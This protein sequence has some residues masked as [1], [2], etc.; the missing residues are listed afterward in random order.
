MNQA[1]EGY[2]AIIGNYYVGK[3]IGRGTFGKVKMGLHT[4]TMENVAI[5]ILDKDKIVDESDKI[6]VA[7]EIQILRK[8]RHPNIIQL[9]EII[10]SQTQLFLITEYAPNNE[11]FDFIVKRNRLNERQSARFLLQILSAVEYL[12]QNNIVHRDLKPENLL[13]DCNN[14]IKVVDFGLSNMYED[15]QTLKTACGSPCYAAPEMVSGKRYEGLK[16]D[17]WSCGIILYAMLCGYL[18]FEDSNTTDLYKKIINDPVKLPKFL[19]DRSKSILNGI[20][21]KNPEKRLTIEAI[22][23]HDF[24]ILNSNQPILKGIIFGKDDILVDPL[25]LQIIK[26]QYG[27]D[28]EQARVMIQNNKHN[29]ITATYYLLLNSHIRNG[30]VS[31]AD[32]SR[33]PPK[34]TLSLN[35]ENN[36]KET[37][38]SSSKKI[39]EQNTILMENKDKNGLQQDKQSVNINYS[40]RVSAMNKQAP[41][42]SSTPIKKGVD[43]KPPLQN[44]E[45][46]VALQQRINKEKQKDSTPES[47]GKN[48]SYLNSPLI[49]SPEQNSKNA[50]ARILKEDKQPFVVV[51]SPL[52]NKQISYDESES[53]NKSPNISPNTNKSKYQDLQSSQK[54]KQSGEINFIKGY[55]LTESTVRK[56]NFFQEEEQINNISATK[57]KQNIQNIDVENQINNQ[58]AYTSTFGSGFKLSEKGSPIR[59]VKLNNIQQQQFQQSLQKGDTNIQ[60]CIIDKNEENIKLDKQKSQES[61]NLLSEK[62]LSKNNEKSDDEQLA[63]KSP[64]KE[65][66]MQIEGENKIRNQNVVATETKSASLD[67]KQINK[68]NN[69][70]Q[71]KVNGV[72]NLYNIQISKLHYNKAGQKARNG[73]ESTSEISANK[74]DNQVTLQNNSDIYQRTDA[75]INVQNY[76][77][78]SASRRGNSSKEESVTTQLQLQIIQQSENPQQINQI[79]NTNQSKIIVKIHQK[80]KS[81]TGFSRKL[82][83]INGIN[84]KENVNNESEEISNMKSPQL[85]SSVA[86][87]SAHSQVN[88]QIK[89]TNEKIANL[90]RSA[91]QKGGI[92]AFQKDVS[93]QSQYKQYLPVFFNN[94]QYSSSLNAP[95]TSNSIINNTINS[96]N[97]NN[98]TI[99]TEKQ[100]QNQSSNNYYSKQTLKTP[101]ITE[102]TYH[103][104]NSIRQKLKIISQ[105]NSTQGTS[106]QA[107]KVRIRK[108]ATPEL[109]NINSSINNNSNQSNIQ[110]TLFVNGSHN[111]VSQQQKRSNSNNNITNNQNSATGNSSNL[112]TSPEKKFKTKQISRSSRRFVSA[113]RENNQMIQQSLVDDP[114]KNKFFRQGS[115][116]IQKNIQNYLNIIEKNSASNMNNIHNTDKQNINVVIKKPEN[117]D[118][119]GQSFQS[120]MKKQDQTNNQTPS[121]NKEVK[122]PKIRVISE[123]PMCKKDQHSN[124]S[125]YYLGLKQQMIQKEPLICN[126]SINNDSN[127]NHHLTN[128][129]GINSTIDDIVQQKSNQKLTSWPHS[130]NYYLNAPVTHSNNKSYL[131]NISNSSRISSQLNEQQLQSLQPPTMENSRSEHLKFKAVTNSL[132]SNSYSLVNVQKYKV[133]KSKINSGL[134]NISNSIMSVNNAIS[135]HTKDKI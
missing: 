9:Y 121:I 12:H 19:T 2:F 50:D 100:Q 108:S 35:Q 42:K 63:E 31:I 81:E 67:K 133:R 58:Q 59:K 8:I 64:I 48:G 49:Q 114:T 124:E 107:F 61:E 85:K 113:E 84:Q 123:S 13:L 117:I 47:K 22:R 24:C 118:N 129:D 104:T 17:I 69:Q 32:L 14:N 132:I 94:Q 30:G 128:N 62:S 52:K 53:S 134:H 99:E 77:I 3:T 112:Q 41:N 96:S 71:Q 1:P 20:L 40:E 98:N 80:T 103:E 21:E 25:I 78:S 122:E 101:C 16:T 89:N 125:K 54:E 72:N 46:Y 90:I 29:Q 4:Y 5:K 23:K 119:N 60:K 74:S 135:N 10:E 130:Q 57:D 97:I 18:P 115:S 126:F 15:G 131:N 106:A 87:S 76:K 73:Q 33:P 7:R 111:L 34:K 55:S 102:P 79:S 37:N 70:N 86:A 43:N 68:T 65:T 83:N 95:N 28:S 75:N 26:N 11:L 105:R 127:I 27:I 36:Q 39:Q 109:N 91:N 6:R 82:M 92:N 44:F 51:K 45:Q 93:A 56:Q 38:E 88:S 110:N 66:K 116:S 120:E